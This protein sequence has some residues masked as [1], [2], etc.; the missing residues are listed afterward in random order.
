MKVVG[1]AGPPGSGKTLIATLFVKRGFKLYTMGDVIRKYA[2]ERRITPDEAAVLIRLERGMR[3]VV[4]GLSLIPGDRIVIDGLRSPEEADALEE[5]L[6]RLFLVYVVAS[7]ETRLK[8]LASR[9]R[10]D[11][12][13][14]YVQFAMRDYREAK[15]GVANL[16]LRADAVIVNEDKSVEELEAEVDAIVKRL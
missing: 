15:L 11:D 3:A 14:S 9:G 5:A 16:L 4:K 2:E 12:P 8:R 7:R 13:A 6:G 1:I 10:L